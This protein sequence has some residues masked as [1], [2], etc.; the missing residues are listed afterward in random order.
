MTRFTWR[1]YYIL[2]YLHRNEWLAPT[3]IGAYNYFYEVSTGRTFTNIAL[4]I[5]G[6]FNFG[7]LN[8]RTHTHPPFALCQNLI[9]NSLNLF[10]SRKQPDCHCDTSL[11]FIGSMSRDKTHAH[12]DQILRQWG[13]GHVGD[14]GSQNASHT[15]LNTPAR[16]SPHT[17]AV[18]TQH[19][20]SCDEAITESVWAQQSTSV[21]SKPSPL[22]CNKLVQTK[23]LWFVVFVVPNVFD[24][25][26]GSNTNAMML[27]TLR[28]QSRRSP[29]R[30]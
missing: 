8:P 9:I 10:C 27:P 26:T 12:G 15:S 17:R 13:T 25:S 3:S 16:S 23:S 24:E 19:T 14:G 4:L 21:K 30:T 2:L 6:T 28:I 22:G 1:Q 11:V 29:Q 5:I 20:I 7:K 18:C